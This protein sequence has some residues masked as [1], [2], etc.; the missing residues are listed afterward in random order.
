MDQVVKFVVDNK[1]VLITFVVSLVA[2]IKLTAWGRAQAA[3]LDTV[4]GAVECLGA[5]D[6]KTK[7]AAAE[8]RLA[9]A[10]RDALKDAVAKADAKKTSLGAVLKFIREVL[11]GI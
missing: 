7:V 1:D 2:V 9:D 10:A 4:V 8:K 11:R 6:V 3:A 5:S